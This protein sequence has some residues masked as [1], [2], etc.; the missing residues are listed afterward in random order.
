[1]GGSGNRQK[2]QAH[3]IPS[4]AVLLAKEVLRENG[5][6]Y[7][8]KEAQTFAKADASPPST[9]LL[10]LKVRLEARFARSCR[11]LSW[12]PLEWCEKAV[13][14]RITRQPDLLQGVLWQQYKLAKDTLEDLRLLDTDDQEAGR[15]LQKVQGSSKEPAGSTR[16]RQRTSGE[17]SALPEVTFD[18]KAK[19]G[20]AG[21]KAAS[22][23]KAD[24]KE[25]AAGKVEDKGK[26]RQADKEQAARDK[27]TEIVK[28]RSS[29]DD[30]AKEPSSEPLSA[31]DKTLAK[32]QASPDELQAF[33]KDLRRKNAKRAGGEAESEEELGVLDLVLGKGK[34]SA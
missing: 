7:V 24:S 34:E 9:R 6:V 31:V 16:K 1:M 25:A 33:L 10:S 18:P 8:E 28:A 2:Q 30:K 11:E 23:K 4:K 12:S 26:G 17:G 22:D 21:E 13:A 5:C 15:D 29:S 20:S 27:G 19:K 14:E 32:L 3:Y